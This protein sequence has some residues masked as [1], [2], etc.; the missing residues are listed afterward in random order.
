MEMCFDLQEM[1]LRYLTAKRRKWS[2]FIRRK[3]T[4]LPRRCTSCLFSQQ[5]RRDAHFAQSVFKLTSFFSPLLS[6][7]QDPVPTRGGQQHQRRN[8][9]NEGRVHLS[10]CST[11]CAYLQQCQALQHLFTIKTPLLAKMI[12]TQLRIWFR[13]LQSVGFLL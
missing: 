8:G 11:R 2:Y 13:T 7:I 9:N 12:P 1:W 4:K 10:C 6:E 5:L 3:Q